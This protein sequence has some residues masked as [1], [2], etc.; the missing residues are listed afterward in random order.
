MKSLRCSLIALAGIACMIL[1]SCGTMPEQAVDSVYVM[2][3]DYQNNTVKGACVLIDGEKKGY[4]DI[5]GRLMFYYGDHSEKEHEFSVEKEG[6]ERV[7]MVTSVQPGQLLYF[8]MGSG[9]YYAEKAEELLD[10]GDL[11]G[12][13]KMIDRALDIQ[14]RNDWKYLKT[15]ILR[16][17]ES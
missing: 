15:V 2:V 4:T 16:R 7:V 8:R 1:A 5:Y 6:Y 10:E 12:A 17:K 13:L 14:E 11:E 3:Y 9:M